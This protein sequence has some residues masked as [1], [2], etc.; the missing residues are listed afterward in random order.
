MTTQPQGQ[1]P[2]EALRLAHWLEH[3]GDDG[4]HPECAKELRR[5]HEVNQAML[6]ALKAYNLKHRMTYGLD[7][8]WDEEIT[9][10]EAAIVKGEQQ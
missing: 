2:V 1:S 6:E 7:G 5:L 10:G 4:F 9:K 8:A 3:H